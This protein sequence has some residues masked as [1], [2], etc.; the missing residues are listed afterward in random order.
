MTNWL[1]VIGLVSVI[2]GIAATAL[3][4]PNLDKVYVLAI[5]TM[6]NGGLSYWQGT[7]SAAAATVAA[8]KTSTAPTTTA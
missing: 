6:I 1:K 4:L 8:A 3:P 2:L 7:V 5:E